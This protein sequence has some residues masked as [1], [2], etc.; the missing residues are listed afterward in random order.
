MLSRVLLSTHTRRWQRRLAETGRRLSRRPHVVSA[1]LQLDDPWSY[2]LVHYLPALA[3][4]YRIELRV[5]LVEALGG[6]YQPAP[7]LLAE[8]AVEDCKRLA[9]EL[10]I[11]FLDK[12][13]TPPI[14][15][16]RALLDTLAARTNDADFGDELREVLTL[17]W[18]GDTEAAVRRTDMPAEKG[19]AAHVIATSQALLKKLGHYNSAMLHYAGEWYWGVDRLHYLEARLDALRAANDAPAPLLA[20]LRQATQ[21]SLPVTPPAAARELPPLELFHS[22]RSPYSYVSLER[23]FDIADAFGLAL[24][25]RPVLPM[26]MRGLKV[27]FPKLLYIAR[28]AKRE[29]ERLGVPFG[30]IADPTGQG[31]ERCLAV[32]AYAET[33]H[34]GRDFVRQA[35]RA[36]WS[37]GID[38]A[39]D[40]GMRKVTA[41]TG[42][43]WPDVAAAMAADDWRGPIEENR[44]SLTAS[45]AWG[46][47][48]VRLG[49]AVFWGQDRDW[50]L[51][52]HIEELCDSGDGILV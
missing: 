42:L 23:Y 35:G 14:E 16:R 36:I 50:L 32:F 48:T 3:A 28:D 52:R 43:F 46:V 41:K 27:P 7:D 10:G 1:F 34:R 33:E 4:R 37:K 24:R 8:Y 47:P 44:E 29:A 30:R 21:Y 9:R 22:F 31:A 18:R 40:K 26:V 51:V 17:F 5:Y 11:P 2:L 20:S 19:R 39:T 15:H 6:G 13:P 49:D 25:I 12:G 38:V 45:G